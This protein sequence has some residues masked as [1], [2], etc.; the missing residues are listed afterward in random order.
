VTGTKNA[1][2][3]IALIATAALL[4]TL[5]GGAGTRDRDRREKVIVAFKVTFT[6]PTGVTLAWTVGGH[7]NPGT[8]PITISPWTNDDT[9]IVVRRGDGITL[10]VIPIIGFSAN[11]GKSCEILVNGQTKDGPWHTVGTSVLTC[12]VEA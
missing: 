7:H 9:P 1:I 6:D 5:W 2:K 10:H 8:P 3:L 12:A 4:W 11:A